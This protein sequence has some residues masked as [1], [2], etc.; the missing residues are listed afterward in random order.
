MQQLNSFPYFSRL[1]VT[2][3]QQVFSRDTA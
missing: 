1:A 3:G 2:R